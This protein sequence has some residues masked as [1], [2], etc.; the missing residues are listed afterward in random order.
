MS[1]R[2]SAPAPTVTAAR[3]TP[4]G[5]GSV[6]AFA[7]GT[8]PDATLAT[9]PASASTPG[10]APALRVG[11]AGYA[12]ASWL[13]VGPIV[14]AGGVVSAVA[15]RNPERRAQ[16]LADTP[17]V[18]LVDDL[19]ALLRLPDLDLVVLSTPTGRHYDHALQVIAAG[20]PVVVEKPL[21]VDLA[22]V[23]EV[24]R[25]ARSAGVP[26]TV[27]LQRRWDQS[28]LIARR[29]A[30]EGVLGDLWRLEYRWERWRPEPKHRWR[31]DTPASGGGGQL[32]DLGPHMVDLAVQLFGPVT[33]VYAEMAAHCQVS[34]DDTHLALHHVDGRVS[35]LDIGS[36]VAA[37]GP[38]LRLIG[39][40]GTYVYDDFTD[41]GKVVPTYPDLADAPGACGWLYRGPQQ[42]EP[43]ARVAG[44]W[45]DFYRQLFEDL[46]GPD[47]LGRLPVPP[48][49][50]VH[51][52]EILDAAQRSA[53]TG[54]VV[55]V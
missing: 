8:V 48:D 7:A 24:V 49:D 19:D 5:G 39:S 17:G 22:E 34:D 4:P 38:R 29:L 23:R 40:T 25:A 18:R 2:E 28:H 9:S 37:P 10:S 14:A 51:I 42:R 11:L 15:T 55:A 3:A 35:H 16:A 6:P 33:S 21:G 43:V 46:R 26:L 13:H 50:V 32:L 41:D 27:F 44:E 45:A 47:P 36:L 54:Q 30:T 12:S 20:L 52:A 31:E 53:A 1:P